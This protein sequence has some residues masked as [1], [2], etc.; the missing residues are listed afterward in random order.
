MYIYF[1]SVS[2]HNR[3]TFTTPH[4][5]ER[6]EGVAPYLFQSEHKT[7]HLNSLKHMSV[8]FEILCNARAITSYTLS[9]DTICNAERCYY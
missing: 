6:G 8:D 3:M 1:K 7:V 4:P 5:R 9:T 2:S